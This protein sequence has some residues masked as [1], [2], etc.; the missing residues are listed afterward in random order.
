MGLANWLS[1]S[2]LVLAPATVYTI[3]TEQWGIA[4]VLV[5]LAIISDLI[6]GP[7]ARAR[8]EASAAG[9]LLDHGSDAI[10]VSCCLLAVAWGGYIPLLLPILV[11]ASFSQ[12]VMDSKALSG[13]QLRSSSLGRWNGIAYFALLP[14]LLLP[15]AVFATFLPP[16]L[17]ST[18]AWVLIT[19][20]LVSMLDRAWTLLQL[21]RHQ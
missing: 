1:L 11:V 5:A 15:P 9:G 2:R 7:V 4:S 12:Y 16:A 21:R 13:Q 17:L 18:V 19:S 14:C 6:D 3:L 20:T 10:Y 8:G